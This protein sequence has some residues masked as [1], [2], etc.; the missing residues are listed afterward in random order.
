MVFSSFTFL[1]GFLPVFL[2][3]YSLTPRQGKNAM[4]LLGSALFYAWGAPRVLPLLVASS[5]FDFLVSRR[6]AGADEKTARRWLALAVAVN[7]SFL[8][9]YK[10]ANFFVGETNRLLGS[11]GLEP[12]PWL[13]IALPIGIS[14]FTFQKISYL[15]DVYRREAPPARSAVDH[16]LY[17]L[18]FPQLI[19]GPIVRYHDV[20]EQIESREHRPA[21][22]LYGAWRFCLGL[23]KKVLIADTLGHVALNV[24]RLDAT[25]LS[26]A[27]AWLGIVCYAY[28]IY[29]DFSGY[30]DMA[31]GLGRMMGFRFLENFDRP[32]LSE[33]ITEFWRRWHI[34]LSRWMRDYLY[35]PLGGNRVPAWRMYANLW[36]VFVLSGLWHGASWNFVAWGAFHGFFLMLDKLFWLDVSSRLPRLVNTLLTFVVVCFGWVLFSAESLTGAWDYMI[37]MVDVVHYGN[38]P[39]AELRGMVIHDQAVVTFVVATA[40]CFFP[41]LPRLADVGPRFDRRLAGGELVGMQCAVSVLLLV[42]STLALAG[43][44]FTPFIYFRF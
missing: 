24:S 43:S 44:S 16:L 28:Q 20:R 37:R 39:G 33:T 15:V 40:I 22:I 34:S 31:I 26:T 36:I 23:G 38:L 2:A 9:W 11:L 21:T 30:S 7:V 17:V 35:I 13:A 25:E 4:L 8:G 5:V 19:A 42:L 10:Y 3:C 32:Y 1:F 12:V 18:S 41:A 6:I 27:W 14:F 29:F